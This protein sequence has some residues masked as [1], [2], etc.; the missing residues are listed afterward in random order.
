MK[1]CVLFLALFAACITALA[2]CGS[3]KAE[4]PPV[5]EVIDEEEILEVSTDTTTPTSEAS[6]KESK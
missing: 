5:A 1:K 2:A 6:A 3:K 4:E